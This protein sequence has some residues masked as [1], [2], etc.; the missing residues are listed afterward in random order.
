MSL[1][2]KNSQS[3]GSQLVVP[4]QNRREASKQNAYRQGAW[5]TDERLLFL[6]G[7]RKHGVGRWKEIGTVLTTR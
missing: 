6:K 2:G 3:S 4:R 7:L 1:V 5:T